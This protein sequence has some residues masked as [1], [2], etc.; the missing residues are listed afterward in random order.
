MNT[1][2]N[3]IFGLCALLTFLWCLKILK[4]AQREGSTEKTLELQGFLMSFSLTLVY[5]FQIA[6]YHL[7][8]MIPLSYIL[9]LLSAVTPFKILW[10]F[11]SSYFFFWHAA[12][13]NLGKNYDSNSQ[14]KIILFFMLFGGYVVLFYLVLF[15]LISINFNVLDWVKY[16]AYL[17]IFFLPY[18]F[19]ILIIVVNTIVNLIA[20]EEEKAF[21]VMIKMG[22][23]L[24]VM[25]I[26]FALVFL[27]VFIVKKIILGTEYGWE[28]SELVSFF[29]IISLGKLFYVANNYAKYKMPNLSE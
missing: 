18:G 17:I 27:I 4:K 28:N 22:L 5:L 13:R 7:I 2:E 12:Y 20:E 1:L 3:I 9:G 24:S 26:F 19:R 21:Y 25:C 23:P 6:P 15:G 10:V 16:L 14:D 8:W 29:I 11:S